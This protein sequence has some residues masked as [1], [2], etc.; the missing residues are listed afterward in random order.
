MFMFLRVM[1]LF[2]GW[3]NADGFFLG[4]LS[5]T[6]KSNRIDAIQVRY[7]PRNAR[8]AS[9]ARCA[10]IVLF[11]CSMPYFEHTF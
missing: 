4:F 11:V 2:V 8:A 5:L 6:L 3:K 10:V 7:D 1:F 9:A